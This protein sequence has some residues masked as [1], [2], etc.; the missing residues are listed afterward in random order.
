VLRE[1]DLLPVYD[2]SEYD[3]VRDLQ[4]PLLQ[5]SVGY[6][7]GV[8]FFTSGWLR[9]ASCGLSDFAQRGGKA[10]VVLSPI[11][12]KRDW[13]A[14]QIGEEARFDEALRSLLTQRVTDLR[15]SLEVDTLNAFS[16]MVADG[17]LDMR[18]A[19]PREADY[20]G[21]Y[22][23][24]VGVF[25]DTNGDAVA[26]HGSL[27]DSIQGSLNGEA[28][29]LFKSWEEGQS[30]Y[31]RKHRSRLEA[32]WDDQ[33]AQFRVRG[34]PDAIKEQIVQLRSTRERPYAQAGMSMD[35]ARA[36][37]PNCPVALHP[38]QKR[39]ILKWNE[40]G[41]RGVF[42]MATGTGKT[43]T[44]LAAAAGT[45]RELGK[46]ALIIVVPYLHLLEQWE[47]NC[48]DFGFNPVLCSGNHGR[49]QIEVKSRIQDFNLGT[50]SSVCILAVHMTAASA[51]FQDAISRL[52]P[53][54]AMFVG[55]EAHGLGSRQLRNALTERAGMRLGLSATPRRWYDEE[56]T[57]AIFSYF[58]KTCF[59]YTLDE[60]IGKY[61]T[62]YRYYPQLVSLT[63]DEA[64]YYEALTLQITSLMSKADKDPEIREQVKKLLLKRARIVS[65]AEEKL[66]AML[67]LLRTLM[68]E[69][70][71]NGRE[72]RD[73]LVYCAPGCHREVLQTVAELGLRC[74]EF[75]HNVSL[76][77]REKLLEQF[78]SGDIQVLVAIKCLDEGVDVPSTR[79]AFIL[80]SSTNPREFVQRRGRILRK[81]REKSEAVVYDY[82]VAPPTERLPLK[83]DADVS[84]LRREM[85]RFVEFA[86]SALNEFQARA[87][88]R[89]ILDSFEM[90]NL[91]D[92]KPWD[93]YHN[94]RQW[95]W[96]NDE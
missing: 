65:S 79:I 31:L 5:H 33:N 28:F 67:R 92:E 19:V 32:L 71:K 94:L 21:N 12:E 44:S 23:D 49:W 89:D 54:Q 70:K 35:L 75:V 78:A 81:A 14:L 7:R 60:A 56:G 10:R 59:E 63:D 41:R 18:F 30:P 86:S 16:W 82:V 29:S 87:T 93:V 51:R 55:D 96:E 61:L 34:I 52:K 22:H 24:K 95:D 43:V 17:V 88:V 85:P 47:R 40:A 90:L 69:D 11:L 45:H 2:S 77:D 25:T 48:R 15:S 74:H 20:P 62:P 73:V 1:L 84:I 46:L 80:A 4:V 8:G 64:G 66:P 13:D 26:L 6:L 53:D 68:D 72:T 27:N 50:T 58:G 9:I 57:A 42:E 36:A 39:A 83:R 91:L 3:L 38:F 76:R 37:G